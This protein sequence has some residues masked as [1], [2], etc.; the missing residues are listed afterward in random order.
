MAFQADDGAF[1]GDEDVGADNC[2]ARLVEIARVPLEKTDVS[3]S[4]QATGEP[5]TKDE[6]TEWTAFLAKHQAEPPKTDLNDKNANEPFMELKVP[7]SDVSGNPVVF[8]IRIQ[9]K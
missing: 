7:K 8:S 4:T 5:L 2:V 3:L 1:Q 6:Q 9:H